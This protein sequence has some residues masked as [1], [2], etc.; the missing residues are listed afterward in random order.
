MASIGELFIELGVKADTGT[1][2]NV[3]SQVKG[4]RTNL[5][6]VGAAFT[7]AIV[8]L[9][10]FVNSALKGVVALQN[11]NNQTGLSIEKLQNFQQAGQLSNLA[12]S[13]DQI[14]QSIGSLQKN[15][16]QIKIG[17]GDIAPFQLLGIDPTSQDAFG[18]IDQLR[19]S[20]KGIDPAIATNLV[21]Q[22]GLSPEFINILK[23][24]R[25]EF[26]LLSENTFLNP[27]QRAN[28]DKLGTSI[29]AVSLRFK[30]LKDQSIA[31]LAPQLTE[32]TQ[33]FFKWLKD[34]GDKI[35]QTI[36]SIAKGI[37]KFA[38]GIGRAVGLV[39]RFLSNTIGLENSLKVLA[40]GFAFLTLSMS[41]FLAGLTAILII[42]DD[43]AV[44]SAGGD[45]LIGRMVESFKQ[46][47]DFAKIL[48]GAG[49]FALIAKNIT[50]LGTALKG[51]AGLALVL[52]PI[53]AF[54]LAAVAF[55]NAPAI[56][57]K[58][59][60][61][62]SETEAGQK[63]GDT[64]LTFRNALENA[65]LG[66]SDPLTAAVTGFVQASINNLKKDA[67]AN[68]TSNRISTTNINNNNFTISGVRDSK[69]VAG[70]VKNILPRQS[71]V[72]NQETLNRTDRT[73]GNSIR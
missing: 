26:E 56:G 63:I 18:V 44:F 32:I 14:A 28:I 11:L 3:Q 58:L 55:A 48:V 34:N 42:L 70:E 47:P 17:Q 57:E 49:G 23:L 29:K 7:G 15:L 21:S 66:G 35:V 59:G 16:A 10:R 43:I 51:L 8:D 24:S 53:T 2:K 73:Q 46:L 69:E 37:A 22:L 33:E 1:L 13:A 52:S 41:P 25:K 60:N 61:L 62:A 9:D 67:I 6:L 5:L 12:L 68:P 20:I 38:E 27:K 36:S 45:S 54:F 71:N 72:V 4:L 65:S 64:L 39:S 30:A 31:K 50:L 40:V 19:E